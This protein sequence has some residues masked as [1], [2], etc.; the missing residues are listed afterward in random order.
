MSPPYN[1]FRYIIQFIMRF[2]KYKKYNSPSSCIRLNVNVVFT[3]IFIVAVVIISVTSPDEVTASMLAG[4]TNAVSL[5]LKMLAIYAVWTSVLK[6]M[7]KTGIDKKLTKLFRP[8][9]RRLFRNESEKA[10]DLITLN[11]AS[12]V[13]GLGNAATPAGIDA[14]YLMDD[15]SGVATKNMVMLTVIAATSLQLLPLTVLGLMTEY[16][17]TAPS[18]IIL[19]SI[20][21][22]FSSTII[23]VLLVAVFIK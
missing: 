14:I 20:I 8:L 3:L 5:S 6:L 21:S 2:V 16:G 22:T 12:N 13:L 17:S 19:P 4:A 10:V 9:T 1:K 18:A 7:E 23:G 11:V 15:K